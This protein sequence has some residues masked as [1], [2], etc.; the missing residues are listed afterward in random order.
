MWIVTRITTGNLSHI[1]VLGKN[2]TIDG[3]G[4]AFYSSD[5][6]VPWGI[7]KAERLFEVR[8]RTAVIMRDYAKI[9]N[10]VGTK[11]GYDGS[12]I[13]IQGTDSQPAYFYMQGGTI[14][15]NY[16]AATSGFAAVN[17]T[18]NGK[19]IYAGGDISLNTRNVVV[20]NAGTTVWP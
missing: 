11:N 13:S 4:E 7:M 17:T 14:T 9:T 12:T 2:V 20:N 10:C 19:F 5:T 16:F 1:L 6:G 15:K 18:T 8:S 3:Q